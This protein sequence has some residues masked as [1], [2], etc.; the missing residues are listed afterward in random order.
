MISRFKVHCIHTRL[1]CVLLE[2]SENPTT[3]QYVTLGVPTG[4]LCV[5]MAGEGREAEG[6]SSPGHFKA[7]EHT[8]QSLNETAQDGCFLSH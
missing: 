6:N 1:F 7:A 3:A 8:V 4:K 5:E 2:Q